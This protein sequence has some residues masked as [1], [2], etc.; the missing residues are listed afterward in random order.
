MRSSTTFKRSSLPKVILN[1]S[2]MVYSSDRRRPSLVQHND[3]I[4]SNHHAE[5][6]NRVEEVSR[7]SK[8]GYPSRLKQL[9]CLAK[10]VRNIKSKKN[11][12]PS[13]TFSEAPQ[14][15]SLEEIMS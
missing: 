11:I 15:H 4:K 6:E 7:R 13:A 10:S 5:L 14:A 9:L 1:E 2:E 12:Y 8:Y 3:D